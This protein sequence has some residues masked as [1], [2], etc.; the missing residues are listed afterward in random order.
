MRSSKLLCVAAAVLALSGC[1]LWPH[2]KT[3]S[4]DAPASQALVRSLAGIV[5]YAL[6]QPVPADAVLEVSLIDVSRQDAPARVITKE[7]VSPVGA[8]PVDFQLV[9]DPADLAQGVDFAVSARLQQG[10]HLLAI[11]DERISVLGRSGEQGP[12]RVALKAVP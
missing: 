9:Y 12:V 4:N 8:S 6:H 2:G 5:V 3:S 10:D 11:N 1:G 7:R